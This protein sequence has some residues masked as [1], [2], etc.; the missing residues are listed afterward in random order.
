M[1]W[2]SFAQNIGCHRM[3]G[4]LDIRSRSFFRD[5]PAEMWNF[6]WLNWRF[7]TPAGLRCWAV[8]SYSRQNLC[9]KN[10]ALWGGCSKWPTLGP[11][12]LRM[13]GQIL[14]LSGA[15]I[16]YN[17]KNSLRD[18]NLR[19]KILIFPVAQKG[20]KYAHWE[21]SEL[22]VVIWLLETGASNVAERLLSIFGIFHL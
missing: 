22:A 7:W 2:V 3:Y 21:V 4:R 1:Y 13:P 16:P 5:F 15:A 19:K 18:F 14:V 20:S 8:S 6:Y 11:R 12:V 10:S 17:S 9:R